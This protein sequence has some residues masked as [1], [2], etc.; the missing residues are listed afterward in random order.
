MERVLRISS[1][2]IERAMAD[3]NMFDALSMAIMIKIQNKNSAIFNF[4]LNK[5]T[6]TIHTNFCTAKTIFGYAMEFGLIDIK[7][8]YHKDGSFHQDLF[9]K[10]FTHTKKRCPVLHI[11]EG[12][13]LFAYFLSESE[14][15]NNKTRKTKKIQTLSDIKDIILK[16]FCA[17]KIDSF[18]RARNKTDV[19]YGVSDKKLDR[20]SKRIKAADVRSHNH[21]N[22]LFAKTRPYKEGEV[23]LHICGLSYQTIADWITGGFVS[24]FKVAR[25]VKLMI[26][27]GLITTRKCASICIY[28]NNEE[29]IVRYIAGGWLY[30]DKNEHRLRSIKKRTF[31]SS[32]G[33]RSVLKPMA[34]L[35]IPTNQIFGWKRHWGTEEK[36]GGMRR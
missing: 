33:N 15:K 17:S 27:E 4:S 7:T 16:I 19:G 11:I 24:R 30:Q 9:V 31:M 34:N 18:Y 12:E 8:V 5:L 6:K 20:L 25:I 36:G 28:G 2:D 3:K 21:I 14:K 22:Q 32:Y 13:H 29:K 35:M 26:K 23:D 1:D 10:K